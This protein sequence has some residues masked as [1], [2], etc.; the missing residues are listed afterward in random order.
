MTDRYAV[1]GNPIAHSRSPRIH[2]LFA[3]QTEQ[4]VSYEA[5]LVPLDGLGDAIADFA[6]NG[7]RGLN[8]TVPFK[9]EAWRL[10]TTRSPEAE[11]AGAVN[12]LSLGDNGKLHGDNTDGTGLL[13]DLSN[14]GAR[15]EGA[16]VL[17]LGAGG[18]ARGALQPLLA[19][20][21][22]SLTLA[23]RTAGRATGLARD[24]ADLGPI[25]GGGFEALANRQFDLI[26]NATAAGLKGEVPPIEGEVLAEGAWCY[27]MMY[28]AEPTAFVRWARNHGAA[29]AL[30][31]L[32]MLVE[33]AAEAFYIWR[34]VR[35][36]T[37]SVIEALRRDMSA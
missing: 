23:N 22:A 4:D 11:R 19:H 9:E 31:G 13:R 18:A 36:E 3:E 28:G 30:D 1:M 27:D 33:Q 26:I 2:A 10:A 7:G 16:R 32:G 34:G 17:M 15:I 12:T 20:K 24:F 21:P 29:R 6:R 25:E 35:P 37:A 14:H 5:L 8:I